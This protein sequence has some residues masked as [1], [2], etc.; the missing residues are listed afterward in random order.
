M[1]GA[2]SPDTAAS[3]G[4]PASQ[5]PPDS[6]SAASAGSESAFSMLA[7]LWGDLR[8]S[9]QGRVQLVSLELKQAGH[10]LV[11]IVI[12]AVAA[13]LLVCASWLTLMV[14]VYLGC[15]EAGLHWAAAIAMVFVL[16]AG[17]A[18]LMWLKAFK[19]TTHLTFPAT[20]R[21]FSGSPSPAPSEVHLDQHPAGARPHA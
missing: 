4:N 17:A 7:G 10:A 8:L 21:A 20:V 6:A 19:L 11:K 13:G 1:I 12:L 18:L 9:V 16:N 3:A 2:E 15:R 5:T 14:A